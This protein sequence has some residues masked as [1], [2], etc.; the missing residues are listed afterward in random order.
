MLL[1]LTVSGSG[2]A[3]NMEDVGNSI[4]AKYEQHDYAGALAELQPLANQGDTWAQ[5][6]LALHY[7]IYEDK[8]DYVQAAI[9]FRKAAE[10]GD[11]SSQYMLGMLYEQGEG[12]GVEQS[13]EGAFK[14][15][16]EAIARGNNDAKKGLD[17]ILRAMGF[18]VPNEETPE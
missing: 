4:V 8:P 18:S 3:Q 5:S 1:A 17:R 2:W 13:A 7:I 16:S 6:M 14:F 11:A 15:Y 12:L 10:Q 9:W